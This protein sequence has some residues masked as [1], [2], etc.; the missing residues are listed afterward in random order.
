MKERNL[1]VSVTPDYNEEIWRPVPGF[2][3]VEASSH[4]RA[5]RVL[6]DGTVKVIK[7]NPVSTSVGTYLMVNVFDLQG[8]IR[9]RSCHQLTCLAFNGPPPEDG[10]VYEVNHKDG[11]KHNN[12]YTNLEWMTRSENCLHAIESGLRKDN[13][14]I[15]ANNVKTGEV[16]EFYSILDM[17]R[18]WDL[19]RH[20]LNSIILKSRE[21][22]YKGE[23]VITVDKSRFGGVKRVN[24]NECAAYDYVNRRWILAPSAR[25][26]GHAT[27]IN[28]FTIGMRIKEGS[29]TIVAGYLF[30]DANFNRYSPIPECSVEE[31]TRQ[32]EKY[33]TKP[34]VEKGK[35]CWVKDYV[36]GEV[37]FYGK[38]KDAA[39]A[40]GL[41]LQL[42][43]DSIKLE[44]EAGIKLHSAK[45]FKDEQDERLF[46]EFNEIQVELSK[47]GL[48]SFVKVFDVIDTERG[49]T[50]R[51]YGI[52]ELA[53]LVGYGGTS[54]MG[55]QDVQSFMSARSLTERYKV[56][57]L[58]N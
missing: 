41:S 24:S 51:L 50:K 55:L 11:D 45:A 7:P 17:S 35:G 3:N 23:W 10:K 21:K 16:Q 20:Q 40:H 4:G 44:Q 28:N 22:P 27:G 34:A 38:R 26:L 25:A 19:P 33:F 30:R 56:H 58:S 52:G 14:P 1:E 8:D 36:T 43:H 29:D 48:K 39:E 53:Q 49:V 18:K 57:V 47:R 9:W 46:P 6:N 54:K 31:A 15:T 5:R 32:R 12:R 2:R 42:I 37:T 13:I